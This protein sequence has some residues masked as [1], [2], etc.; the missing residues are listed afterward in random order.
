MLGLIALSSCSGKLGSLSADNFTVTPAPLE[1]VGDQVPTTINGRFPEK[2]M[3][4]KAV[5]T[6]VP[7]LRYAGTKTV[8]QSATFQGENVVGND[9]TIAYKV[10]GN[11]VMRTNFPYTPAMDR[12]ELYLTFDARIGNKRVAIPEV[13]IA[14]GVVATSQLV[15]RTLASA[16]TATAADGYQQQIS[17]RQNAQIKYLI[18]QAKVRTSEL[19]RTSV[20]DFVKVLREIKADRKS[21]VLDNIEVAAY[22]SP[23]G[24]LGFNTKLAENRRNT[25]RQYVNGQLKKTKL[26]ANVDTK[27]T[28]EDWEGFKELVEQSNIQDKEAIVRVLSLYQDPEERE[29]QIRNISQAF[30][31]LANEILPELRRARL[32]I[33]YHVVGRT[34]DEIREQYV[35]DPAKLSVEELLYAATLTK[36]NAERTKIFQT[37]VRLYPTDKRAHNGLAQIAYAKGDFDAAKSELTQAGDLAEANANAALIAIRERRLDQAE[38]LLGKA[39]NAANYNE[40][41]GNLL[42]ARGNFT[43]AAQT[44][45]G[46]NSNTAALAQILTKDYV[47]AGK[48]LAALPQHNALTAYLTAIVSTRTGN[49]DRAAQAL[50][51]AVAADASLAGLAQT[52]LELAKVLAQYPQLVK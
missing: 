1:A 48:T 45:K 42:V 5:V 28:A 46:V 7:E 40:V 51:Q 10:G 31:E 18:N 35:N 26:G 17:R 41:L 32:A 44:L 30:T 36:D 33:N 50:K 12:S 47:A 11:Y 23:D 6:V 22:A 9:Q 4:K 38:A 15:Y 34:D 20:Q 25:A 27:Y 8:G 16:N 21:L 19:N 24:S 49:I 3:K 2:Y 13:K 43:Q 37:A 14:D 29:Q 52:D 39:L